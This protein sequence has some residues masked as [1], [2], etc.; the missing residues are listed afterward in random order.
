VFDGYEWF[1]DELKSR[2][3]RPD[4]EG[5]VEFLGYVS[6]TWPELAAADVVLVP[7]RTEPFGNT[8]VE[9]MLARRPVV[10]SG[11]QGLS[12]VVTD[13]RTGLLVPPDDPA[14]LAAAVDG[15]LRDGE[16]RARLADAGRREALDRFSTQRYGAAMVAELDAAR[17]HPIRGSR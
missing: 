3:A 4:L 2:A 11:V 1:E 10:A 16:L 8:A 9:G 15:L 7:S 14:R 17:R 13:G 5:R 6:P 12:E